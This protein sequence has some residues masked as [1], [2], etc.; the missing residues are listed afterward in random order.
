M[1]YT[2]VG[3]LATRRYKD[4]KISEGWCAHCFRTQKLETYRLCR[5]CAEAN[6]IRA[7]KSRGGSN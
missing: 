7:G 6:R 1:T 3:R 5:R 2:E 4:R